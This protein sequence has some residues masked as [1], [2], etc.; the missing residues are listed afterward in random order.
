M[1]ISPGPYKNSEIKQLSMNFL[2]DSVQLHCI[3]MQPAYVTL[4]ALTNTS[5][6]NTLEEREILYLI[7]YIH[8]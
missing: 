1:K 3:H 8:E 5:R 4:L 6:R 2:K 7:E